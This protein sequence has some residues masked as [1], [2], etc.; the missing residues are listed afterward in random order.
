MPLF[1]SHVVDWQEVGHE[2]ADKIEGLESDMQT[3]K[4]QYHALEEE[5]H[6]ISGKVEAL[7]AQRVV[8]EASLEECRQQLAKV[9]LSAHTSS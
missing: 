6:I 3:L 5:N 7:S 9:P 1:E 4:S 8:N 2:Q